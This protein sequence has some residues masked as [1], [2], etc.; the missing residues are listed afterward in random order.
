M[1]KTLKYFNFGDSLINWVKLFYTDIT[2]CVSNNGFL[3]ESFCIERGV[4]QGCPL[5]PYLFII[6]IELLS[7]SV[8]NNNDIT[9]I[10]IDEKEFKNSLFADDASFFSDG[11]YLS[12]NTLVATVED[13]RNVSGLKLNTKKSTVLRTG[14]LRNT[15]IIYCKKKGFIWTSDQAKTLGIIFTNDLNKRLELNFNPKLEEMLSI[16]NKWKKHKL[17]ILGKITVIK[18]F[19]LPKIIY[20]LTVL[21]NPP[22]DTLSL[23]NDTFF[24]FIWDEKPDK[25]SRCNIKKRYEQEGLKMV[26]IWAYVN[27]IKASWVKRITSDI[28][29][30][31]KWSLIYKKEINKF[32]GAI[33]F[34]SNLNAIDARKMVKNRFLRD[35]LSAWCEINFSNNCVN[36][37][38]EIL[39]NNS[40]IKHE[41][42][43]LFYKKWY[44]NGLSKISQFLDRNNKRFYSFFEIKDLYNLENKRF[45]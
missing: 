44:E 13:F 26:D 9:G 27:S 35:V 10:I 18:T 28:E 34:K 43:T 5:S 45:F 40:C 6:A 11:S 12:F 3:S 7:L 8:V 36:V 2:G 22:P 23:I 31:G 37:H 24:K 15:D 14:S 17:S 30:N 33:L 29:I 38:D 42:R 19:A 25:I 1:L 41:N 32:G 20:P 39:W 4:R 16:L 21:E